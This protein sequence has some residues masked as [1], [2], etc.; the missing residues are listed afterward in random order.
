ME[1]IVSLLY[2]KQIERK[3]KKGI[4]L[5]LLPRKMLDFIGVSLS[6]NNGFNHR[7]IFKTI[8]CYQ[9]FMESNNVSTQDSNR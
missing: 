8:V 5:F 1:V 6:L 3:K 2:S 9:I 4:L 7:N